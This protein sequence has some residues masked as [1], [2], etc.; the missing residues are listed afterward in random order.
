MKKERA[1]SLYTVFTSPHLVSA[2]LLVSIKLFLAQVLQTRVLC[3]R[4]ASSPRQVYILH[5]E[6]VEIQG[7]SDRTTLQ[8]PRIIQRLVQGRLE[9]E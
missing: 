4:R 1:V 2:V 8:I 3:S 9:D 6:V 5:A 7:G